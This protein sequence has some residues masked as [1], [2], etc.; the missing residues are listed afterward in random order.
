MSKLAAGGRA[1]ALGLAFLF[2]FAPVLASA[3]TTGSLAGQVTDEKGTPLA[4]AS[5]KI[6][7]P[8]QTAVVQ[9]DAHGR[10]AFLSLAPDTYDVTTTKT[11]YTPASYPGVTI[12]ADQGLTLA[13]VIS[14]KSLKNI[15]TVNSRSNSLVKPGTTASV[16][17]VNAAA[18][19]QLQGSGGG[20]NLDSSYSAIYAQPGVSS[21]IGNYGRICRSRAEFR[22]KP[23][24]SCRSNSRRSPYERVCSTDFDA[25]SVRRRSSRSR[26]GRSCSG[27]AIDSTSFAKSPNTPT[28]DSTVG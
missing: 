11:G 15:A 4:G 26:R 12:F 6:S 3:G 14:T 27:F 28:A 22:S 13:I 20:Y 23:T 17:S 7:S 18:Q 5:V 9:T 25:R 19:T 10:F 1:A 21:Y 8:S 2:A 24:R 16:Y